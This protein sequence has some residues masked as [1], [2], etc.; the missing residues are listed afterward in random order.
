MKRST[1]LSAFAL[2][3]LLTGTAA[4]QNPPAPPKPAKPAQSGMATHKP[5]THRVRE[6]KPGLLKQAKVSADSAERVAMAQ[7]AGGTVT[8]R[9]IEKQKGTGTLVY[10]FDIKVPGQEGYQEVTVDATT[11]AFV[12]NMHE[13]AKMEKKEHKATTKKP[14]KPDT[15]KPPKKP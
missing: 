5:T 11:G 14:V 12:S 2:A 8:A 15:T 6:A 4:A 9:E 10:S 1:T 13:T 7:V 3:A